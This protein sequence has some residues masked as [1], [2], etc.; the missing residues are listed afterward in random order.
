MSRSDRTQK[1]S[2]AAARLIERDA[3]GRPRIPRVI[4]RAPTPGDSHP[5][6]KRVLQRVLRDI[7]VEYV[8]GLSRIELRAR[9]EP[10]VG[11]PFG[12]YRPDER[13]IILYSLPPVWHFPAQALAGNFG[14]SLQRFHARIVPDSTGFNISWPEP[15]VMSLWFYSYVFT[16]E[17]GHHFVEQYK[18]KNSRIQPSSA[19]ELVA[20]LHAQRLTDKLFVSLRARRKG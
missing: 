1:E 17:L 10:G 14:R 20:G 9:H 4:E 2:L 6:P 5:I 15:A 11:A 18:A 19:E 13:A 7:P 3:D 16:H 8:Y 12:C